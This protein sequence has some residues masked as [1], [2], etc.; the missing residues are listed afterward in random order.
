VIPAPRPAALP[1][2]PI[3]RYADAA[4]AAALAAFLTALV[5]SRSPQRALAMLVAGLPKAAHVGRDAYAAQLGRT[6]AGRGALIADPEACAASAAS[7]RS[8]VTAPTT[9]RRSGWPTWV[10]RWAGA[11]PP[12]PGRPPMWLWDDRLETITQAIVEGRMMWASVRDALSILLGGNLGEILF[13]IGGGILG[14]ADVLNA[15]QLLLVNLLTDML[16]ALAVAVRRPPGITPEAL[17]AEGPEASLGAA[18]TRDVYLRAAVTAAAAT[19]A[20]LLARM[21]GP[22][23]TGSTVALVGLVAAQLGQTMAVDRRSWLVFGSALASLVALVVIVQ[24]PVLSQLF[25]CRPLGLAA[26]PS[27]S[28]PRSAGPRRRSCCRGCSRG[29]RDDNNPSP[30]VHPLDHVRPSARHLWEVASVFDCPVRARNKTTR[31]DATVADF[32]ATVMA[33]AAVMLI[34][35]L[36]RW[37]IQ[38]AFTSTFAPSEETAVAFA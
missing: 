4:T 24:T 11:P 7:W 17:L 13:T 3:E 37:F 23:S 21:T 16:P 10:W 19:A 36:V 27:V 35:S 31:S 34:E 8:P 32:L 29:G 30:H 20:W 26:G 28:V 6:A 12:P 33:K 25:G 18:L 14:G 5:T 38:S 9:R 2:G 22:R 15:R 1:T